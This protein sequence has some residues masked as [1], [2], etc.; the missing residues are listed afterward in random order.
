MLTTLGLSAVIG[1]A[2]GL[3][4]GGGSILT[5]PMLVYVLHVEPKQAI[6]T[7][8]VV[9]GLSS[10]LALISHARRNSV[11]WKSGLAFGFSGML[12]ALG[13]SRLAVQFSSEL[14]MGLFGLVSLL[15]GGLMMR[16]QL[17]QQA[18][19]PPSTHSGSCPLRVPYLRVLFDGFLVGGLTAMVGVG[20]GF[21]IVP[22]MTLLI[23]LPMQAAVGTSLLVIA[24]N[25]AAGL[26][27]Y[28][29]HLSLDLDLTLLVAAG[30]LIG[31][32]LGARLSGYIRP[33]ALR[34]IFAAMVMA[35]AAYVLW[36]TFSGGLPVEMDAL[37]TDRIFLGKVL[38][39]LL[40]LWLLGLIGY[41]VHKLDG[42]AFF[43]R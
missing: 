24:M 27:G 18:V 22:A 20:G 9:V 26:I 42:I 11:C 23:G 31:S 41:W 10:L 21:M 37:L 6:V 25:A 35:V 34:R 43:A 1:L 12:G 30:T 15:I 40:L 4:G 8:F 19:S 36:Q 13:G 7:S 2:L 14:L 3:L 29:Q 16:G 5:V 32:F 17:K 33:Q 38:V 39:G 28:S